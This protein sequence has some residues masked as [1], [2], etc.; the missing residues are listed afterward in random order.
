MKKPMTP[1]REHELIINYMSFR[2]ML[3]FMGIGLPIVLIICSIVWN[4]GHIESSISNYYYTRLRDVFVVTLCAM[5][6]FL[7]T[8]KGSDETDRW[9][10][11]LAGIFGLI[12][13]FIPTS[14]KHDIVLPNYQIVSKTPPYPGLTMEALDKFELLKGT[15]PHKIIPGDSTDLMGM[16]HLVSAAL[17]FLFLGYMSYFQFSKPKTTPRKLKQNLFKACG[18]IIFITILALIPCSLNRFEP[19][20][21]KYKLIFIGETICLFAFGL[22]WLIK[23][24]LILKDRPINQLVD[25]SG[26]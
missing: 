3:G 18:L 12:T 17:F 11:N 10:T 14:F 13:A 7:L 23:G 5:S 16:V 8:Y 15:S 4:N 19:F 6:L 20:Y 22:S 25:Q 24:Q 26:N 9:I 21:A 1:R 2:K